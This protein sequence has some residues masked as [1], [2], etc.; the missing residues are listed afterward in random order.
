[1]IITNTGGGD[2]AGHVAIVDTVALNTNG[3]GT[4]NAIEQNNSHTGRAVYG[5][6]AGGDITRAG[7]GRTILGLV[8][9]VKNSGSATHF[10]VMTANPYVAGV[11]HTVTVTAKDVYGNTATGYLGTIHF[12]STDTKAVLPADYTFVAADKGVH[13]FSGGL[14]LKTA[15]SRSVT[16]TDKTT[17]SIKGSQTVTVTPAAAKT[18]L[19]S[20]ANPYVAGAGHTVT[21]TAK[22]VYGNTATGYRGTIHFTSSDA[23]AVMPA[24]YTFLAADNGVHAFSGGLHLKTAGSRSVTATDTVTASITGSQTVTVTPA[25]ATHFTVSTA[26]P[27]VAGAGHTVTVTALD[28]YG[29]TASGYLGK[30]HFT[31][32]DP[33]AV[34][35][36]DYTF[37][38]ADKG[39]HAFSG[40]LTLKTAGSRSVTATDKASASIAGSQTGIAVSPGAATHFTVSTANPYVHGVGHSVTITALDAY[41]N[42]ATGYLGTIH[43][44]S[45][46]PAA[47]LPADYT[48]T[49]AAKGVHV[50]TLT[51]KTVGTRT[52]TVTD[53][54]HASITGSQTISVT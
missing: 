22:D 21:V 25:A 8:H 50:L 45:T 18:L 6:T 16:A 10:V 9:A 7:D 2:D 34:L 1:M 27:Y 30:I 37:V 17:S 5:I 42:T 41:G 26:N 11:G 3:S 51:L 29:N 38:A 54:S 36:A 14:A 20:T 40:G 53:K 46:D 28:A 44:T 12:S 15:G 43:F 48:F 4:I 35:P 32:T 39:V 31:S 33:A 13:A 24:N 19:V 23:A 52:V 47:V 49:A